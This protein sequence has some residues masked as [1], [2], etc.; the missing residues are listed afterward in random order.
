[1]ITCQMQKLRVRKYWAPPGA[2]GGNPRVQ[3][4]PGGVVKRNHQ[5]WAYGDLG[6]NI[7]PSTLFDRKRV[8]IVGRYFVGYLLILIENEKAIA[9]EFLEREFGVFG[10]GIAGH[11][12]GSAW[13]G[14]VIKGEVKTGV[15]SSWKRDGS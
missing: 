9:V 15:G 12:S 13:G 7:A 1:M 4:L 5:S 2:C 6:I 8:L 14:G 10:M 3:L 11:D